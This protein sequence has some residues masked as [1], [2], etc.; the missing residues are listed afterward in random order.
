VK[1][2]AAV[3]DN[4][5]SILTTAG[6]ALL[7]STDETRWGGVVGVGFEY[8][9]APNWSVGAEYDHLFMGSSTN[10][11]ATLPVLQSD[12]IKQDVDLFT[13][14]VNYKFGGPV[15]ARY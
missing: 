4:R 15:V 2:G 7:A 12:N 14:R 13:A 9:F 11:F 1:G 6:G 8:G 3:T 10:N 5:Y